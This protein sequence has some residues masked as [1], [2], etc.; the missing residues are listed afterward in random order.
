MPA[1]IGA[2]TGSIGGNFLSFWLTRKAERQTLRRE[3]VDKYL[4]QLQ[5]SLESLWFRLDNMTNRDGL[6]K[7]GDRYYEVSTLYIL[8][9]VLAH[10]RILSNEGAYTKINQSIP[11]LGIFLRTKMNQ[12]GSYLDNIDPSVHFYQFDRIALSEAIISLK[13]EHQTIGSYFEFRK[14]FEDSNSNL[15]STLS[16]AT[17]FIVK[18]KS[19][20]LNPVMEKIYEIA[21]KIDTQTGITTGIK[22][23]A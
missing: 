16:P 2:I 1:L 19:R 21:I 6:Q 11:G 15:K 8:G 3:L 17:E 22:N 18:I 5:D 13:G 20:D 10:N 4:I 12:F 9:S 14:Q 23:P 7:M